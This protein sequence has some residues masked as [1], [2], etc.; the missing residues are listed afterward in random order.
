VDLVIVEVSSKS[1]PKNNLFQNR[2][3]VKN[4]VRL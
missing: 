4:R 3:I 2:K 1:I